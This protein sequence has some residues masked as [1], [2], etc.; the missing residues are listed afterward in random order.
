MTSRRP[1]TTASPQAHSLKVLL[2]ALMILGGIVLGTLLEYAI[3]HATT[4]TTAAAPVP[5]PV[6]AFQ[7]AA[8][9]FSGEVL[10]APASLNAVIDNLRNAIVGLL[11][12]LATFFLTV[13]GVPTS[14]PTAIPAKSK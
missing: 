11:V 14:W 5:R 6:P 7:S 10:A 1:R 4:A 12:A 2:V 3:A 9:S 8:V 13:G